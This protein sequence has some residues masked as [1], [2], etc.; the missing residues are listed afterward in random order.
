MTKLQK[1]FLLVFLLLLA[2]LVYLEAMKPKPIS[3]FPSYAKEDRIPYGTFVLHDLLQE[4]FKSGF[5]E[6]NQPPFE[7]LKDS[8]FSG[9]Y[10]FINNQVD[11][12]ETEVESL[13]AWAEAGN[14]VFVSAN[15]HSEKLLD[16]LNLEMASAIDYDQIRTEPLLNLTNKKLASPTPF[17]LKQ[18]VDIRYFQEI[19]T[20]SQTVLGVSQVFDDTLKIT[21]PLANFIKAPFG[22]GEI[23]LHA[24][25]EI[26]SN[27]FLLAEENSVHSQNVLS[28]LNQTGKQIYWDDY[29]K[30][31]KHINISPLRVLLGNKQLKWA[32]YFV[33]I[34]AALFI[35][36]E[37]KRKQRSIP[38]IPPLTNKSYEYARTVAG[39]YLNKNGN[40]L[41]AKKQIALFL[42]FI[43]TR[44]RVP[45]ETFNAQFFTAIAARS[46]NTEEA[47]KN[48]FVFI[49]KLEKQTPIT[50]EDLLK[51]YREIT[52]Y[53][54]KTDGKH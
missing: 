2:A 14:T 29:Y 24:Q 50:N 33:L 12:D 45:T 38:I 5:R 6:I 36:F 25:P 20:P 34:G 32:Y 39:M 37:G 11:F 1:T 44:L 23:Y 42:E 9:I 54:K 4:N 16:S 8:T 3:W 51:L 41:I 35:I 18:N 17:H 13:L 49:E 30:T 31:G 47:T 53:K 28:Y 26:F 21:E 27:F 15:Y 40:Q 22:K 48:L 46:G 19:D 43:R 10:L 7:V 52:T